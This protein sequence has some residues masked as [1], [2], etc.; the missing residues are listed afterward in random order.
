MTS[1][2]APSRTPAFFGRMPLL[3]SEQKRFAALV[4]SLRELGVALEVGFGSLPTRLDPPKLV[5]ELGRVLADHFSEAEDCLREVAARRRDLLPAI[6]DMR[7]DH[8]ML[9]QSLADLRILVADQARWVELPF[10][11]ANL[12]DKLALHR[13]CEAGLVREA[14]R[15]ANAA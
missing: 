10:R 15:A 13:E 12:L 9:A 5:D 6:V 14:T 11:L 8:A 7:S 1:A 3:L 2:T 4:D